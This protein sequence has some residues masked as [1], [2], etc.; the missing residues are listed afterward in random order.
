[1]QRREQDA[2]KDALDKL[3]KGKTKGGVNGQIK[4]QRKRSD[5]ADDA[6]RASTTSGNVFDETRNN[7]LNRA[8]IQ[9][10]S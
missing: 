8:A 9:D 10:S 5:T 1:M 4:R 2:A 3:D 7:G 6:D